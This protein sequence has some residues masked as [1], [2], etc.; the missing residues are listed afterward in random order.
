[1]PTHNTAGGNYCYCPHFTDEKTEAQRSRV[2]KDTRL[3]SYHM[4]GFRP[5]SGAIPESACTWS[6]PSLGENPRRN[7]CLWGRV[8]SVTKEACQ[9]AVG[10]LAWDGE[11]RVRGQ[12]GLPGGGGI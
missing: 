11:I 9:G 7:P 4:L 8:L 2:A 6:L 12:R 1:M 10:A 3:G 5:G